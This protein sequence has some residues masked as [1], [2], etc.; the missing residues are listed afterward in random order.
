MCAQGSVSPVSETLQRRC[1]RL[2]RG[3]EDRRQQHQ[4][5]LQESSGPPGD[6]GEQRRRFWTAN[7]L[8]VKQQGCRPSASFGPASGTASSLLMTPLKVAPCFPAG[9]QSL[10]GG[11]E[12]AARG[13]T[14]EHGRPQATTGSA[15]EEVTRTT[16]APCR[17][18]FWSA[19]A[20][21]TRNV[22]I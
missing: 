4:S 15:E 13:P 19:G 2:R 3:S 22:S 10:R 6:E 8:L 16:A 12:Q 1:P 5:A 14:P 17:R 7:F 18:R 20:W 21:V 11:P 9:G